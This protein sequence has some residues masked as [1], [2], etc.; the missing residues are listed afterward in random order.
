[1]DTA[2]INYEI[3]DKEI[4]AVVSSFKQWTRYLKRVAHPISVFTDY[5]NFKYF[6]IMKIMNWRQAL[7]EHE[8]A[9]YN[10]K[11]FLRPGSANGKTDALSSPSEYRPK[12]G[13]GSA[14]EN[15]NQPIHCV[16]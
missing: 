7:S 1:M 6:T 10:F 15:Q 12:I 8:L 9:Y 2:V 13:R 3:Q 11:I 16:L 4:L 5:K 14:E